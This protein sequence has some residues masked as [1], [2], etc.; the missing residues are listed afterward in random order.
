M[1][2]LI[3]ILAFL[4]LGAVTAEEDVR[5]YDIELIVY[6]NLEPIPPEQKEVKPVSVSL[7]KQEN[8]V[9]LGQAFTGSLPKK[10][11]TAYAFTPLQQEELQ[12][13]DEVNRI[14]ESEK[15]RLLLHTGWRQPGL[16][17][18][19]ALDIYFKHLASPKSDVVVP[20]PETPAASPSAET[21]ANPDATPMP[22]EA[23]P[24]IDPQTEIDGELQG[25]IKIVLARYLHLNIELLYKKLQGTG[26]VDLFDSNYVEERENDAVYYLKQTRRMRSVELHYIDHPVVGA[27]VRI[28]Q[29]VPPEPVVEEPAAPVPIKNK[30]TG[31]IKR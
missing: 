25:V 13:S 18:K 16:S 27:L 1:R 23:A 29:F 20:L 10:Y 22:A 21:G 31:T 3:L 30:T 11:D 14:R 2:P 4:H 28:T 8:A 5:Y 7:E 19:E 24:E 6:E 9:T 12:L 26:A 17:N 15:Y